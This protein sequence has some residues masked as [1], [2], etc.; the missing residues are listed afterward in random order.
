MEDNKRKE[1]L[2]EAQKIVKQ[3]DKCSH[4]KNSKN[5]LTDA[6]RSVDFYEGRQWND[7]QMK[8]P[9]EKPQVNIIQ[10]I[11]D[12]KVANVTSKVWHLNFVI[13][14]DFTTTNR[15]SKFS[16]V[17]QKKMQQEDLN[18]EFTRDAIIKGTGIIVY[19]WNP[20][21]IGQTGDVE[22]EL[23]G[24]IIDLHDFACSDPSERNIQKQE[25]IIWRSR[26]SIKAV[27]EACDFLT[28]KEK[29][30]YIIR[31]NFKSDYSD[32]N[33]LDDDMCYVYTKM[34]RQDNEVYFTKSTATIVF[35]QA[36]ALN[37]NVNIKAIKERK[38]KEKDKDE[39][40]QDSVVKNMQSNIDKSDFTEE[41][42]LIK[43]Y[44]AHLYPV[45]VNSFLR[46]NNCIFGI[47]F[48]KQMIPMQKIINQL[49]TTSVMCATKLALPTI[50]VKEGALGGGSIDLSKPGAIIK[51]RS[52]VG[53]EG[54]R[55]LN[56]GTIPTA[57]YELAQSMVA[58][59]KD[60][61]R[62]NDMLNDGRNIGTNL[63][64]VALQ[65][66]TTI[67]EMPVAQ[68]QEILGRTLE[69]EGLILEMFYK[70]FY[71]RKSFSYQLSNAEMMEQ[72]PN[73]DITK[74]NNTV[75]DEW[76]GTDYLDTPFNVTVEAGEGVKY[77]EMATNN[78][79]N[80]LMNNG[81]IDKM[82]TESLELIM[83]LAPNSFFPKRNEFM[84]MLRQRKASEIAQL[85][86]ENM[87][88]QQQ[89]EQMGVRQQAVEQEYT[90]KI[91]QYNGALKNYETVIKEMQNQLN[92]QGM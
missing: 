22:G 54:I 39:Y 44:K 88:L 16:E 9:F 35:Q 45:V 62:A 17:Q 8:V 86:Q 41:E 47:S 42:Q 84:M 87:T 11:V 65:Q 48:V 78:M 19:H 83:A 3:F 31:D 68:W 90:D 59:S 60:V 63:S 46:R 27:K 80:F 32:D 49:L 51:D 66:L 69:Q 79:L 56:T 34:F 2:E 21:S 75:S 38:R 20:D 24:T 55:L 76:N 89:L 36:T 5:I 18:L 82:S 13:D 67:Q 37:P 23:E 14:A 53:E 4:F 70:L 6:E 72:Y 58:L 10:N 30:E 28:D 91:N 71:R 15:L 81:T 57:H 43:K 73:E 12:Q 25:Y 64:A 26:E 61:Y 52:P 29:D 33:T 85:Q 40:K 74:M 92:R 50:I 7:V 77:S 1:L